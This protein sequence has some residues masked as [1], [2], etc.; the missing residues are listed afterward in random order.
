[1]MMTNR[2][3]PPIIEPTNRKWKWLLFALVLA[4]LAAI[5]VPGQSPARVI[6]VTAD[7]DSRFKMP[8]MTKPV[9]TV[10]AGESIVMRI[11]AVKAKTHNR[12]GSVHGFTLLRA[13]DHQ[14]VV[15]WDFLLQP[16]TQD[17]AVRAPLE[18]GEYEVVC[19]VICSAAHEGMNMKFVV[20]PAGN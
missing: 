11:T 13:K 19:T 12:D 18:P 17:I 16:G 7:H 9:I 5:P 4:S 6:E 15:G 2:R 3:E 1:M 14:P 20:L 8:G 10:T